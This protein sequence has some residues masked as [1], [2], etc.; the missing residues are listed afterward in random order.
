MNDEKIA[1]Q[2]LNSFHSANQNRSPDIHSTR[3]QQDFSRFGNRTRS[4]GENLNSNHFQSPSVKTDSK[5]HVSSPVRTNKEKASVPFILPPPKIVGSQVI[6]KKV[7]VS[8]NEHEEKSTEL[9]SSTEIKDTDENQIEKDSADAL[10]KPSHIQQTVHPT[11]HEVLSAEETNGFEESISTDLKNNNES[12]SGATGLNEKPI[13]EEP[14]SFSEEPSFSHDETSLSKEESR[15]IT[16]KSSSPDE[17]SSVQ[18]ES[19]SSTDES[20]SMVEEEF[21]SPDE[22]SSIVE[23]ESSSPYESTSMY[24]EDLS[25]PDESL[26]MVEEETS[27]LDES[28]S[29]QEESSSTE[30]SSPIHEES[31]SSMEDFSSMQEESSSST[32]ES[33]SMLE[34]SSSSLDESSAMIEEEFSTPDDSFS[35]VEEESSSLDEASSVQEKSSS[36]TEE[37]S[38]K[39]EEESSSLD[40]SSLIQE[41][42]PS[43]TEESSSIQ[44]ESSSLPDESSSIQEELSSSLDEPTSTDEKPSSSIKKE[45]S[46]IQEESLREKVTTILEDSSSLQECSEKEILEKAD[47][48]KKYQNKFQCNEPLPIVKL[49]VLLAAINIDVDIFDS[50]DLLIP[51]TKIRKIDWTCHSLKVRTVLPSNTVFLKGMLVADIEYVNENQSNSFHTFKL[52]VP[53]KKITKIDWLHQPVMPDNNHVEYTFQS[54]DREEISNHREYQEQFAHPIYHDLRSLNFVW[55][56]EVSTNTDTLKLFIQGRARL[57]IDLLQQQYIDLHSI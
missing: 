47:K 37:S 20:S 5:K 50:Y 57:C 21:S 15:S 40:E 54:N 19:S 3:T 9:I 1:F 17:F 55:S 33:S 13:S 36:S 48:K 30:E 34:E 28:S 11:D 24:E 43:L 27:S 49:P 2:Q 12:L 18:E 8:S 7:K 14:A 31:A 6:R 16:E 29:V 35:M 51:I 53:W 23:E 22:S 4:R 42:S 41:E 39:V 44:E 25:L 46:T 38:S 32:E 56:E 52:Q 10:E 45:A 26:T